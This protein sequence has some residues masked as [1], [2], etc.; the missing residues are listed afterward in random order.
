MCGR[1]TFTPPISPL[2]VMLPATPCAHSQTTSFMVAPRQ[3][4]ALLWALIESLDYLD[5]CREQSCDGGISATWVRLQ[6]RVRL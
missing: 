4:M 2:V 5:S 6:L 1:V 3:D